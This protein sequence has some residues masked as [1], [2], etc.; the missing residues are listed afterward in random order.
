VSN[1]SNRN[2]VL[3][4]GKGWKM[5]WRVF[6]GWTARGSGKTEAAGLREVERLFLGSSDVERAHNLSNGVALWQWEAEELKQTCGA[7]WE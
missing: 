5:D 1:T 6:S 2:C 3:G 7:D 4:C